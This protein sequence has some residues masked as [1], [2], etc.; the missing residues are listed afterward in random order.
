MFPW[1][2]FLNKYLNFIAKIFFNCLVECSGEK[3]RFFNSKS[4]NDSNSSFK[5]ELFTFFIFI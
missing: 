4:F 3:N 5:D 1:F 2:S